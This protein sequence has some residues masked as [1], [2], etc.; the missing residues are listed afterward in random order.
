MTDVIGKGVI[1]VSADATKM[2]A[3]IGEAKRSIK[4]LGEAT[5]SVSKK[6]SDSIDRYVKRLEVQAATVGKS[7]RETKLYE[8]ALRGASKAQ[9]DA[10][11][12]ALRQAEGYERGLRIGKSLGPSLLTIGKAAV[13]AGTGLIAVAAGF[14][15]FIKKAGSFQDLAEKTGDTAQN[16]ASLAVAAAVGGVEMNTVAAASVKLT[17]GLT[18]VDDETKGA[19]AAI[20]ALG[21]DLQAFKQLAPADQFETVAKA[22]AGF[23]NGAQQ[24]AVAV[25]LFGKSGADILPFLKELSQE[26]SRQVILTTEQIKLAD[27]YADKQAKSRAQ[28]S[29]LASSIATQAIPAYTALQDALSDTIKAL[30]GVGSASG[31]LAKRNDVKDFAETGALALAVLADGAYFIAQ[32]FRLVGDNIGSTAAQAAALARLDFAGAAAIGRASN[33]FNENLKLSLG[34]AD[35]LQAKFAAINGASGFKLPTRPGQGEKDKPTLNFNGAAKSGGKDTA[36]QE[37]ASQLAFDLDQIKKASAATLNSFS[38]AERIL[39]AKRSA[40]LVQEGEYYEAKLR[41]LNVNRAEQ[42]RALNA[43]IARLQAEKLVGKDKIDND[44]KIMDAQARLAKVREDAATSIEVQGIQQ[45]AALK[46]I[47]Q[48]YR[49]AEDAANEFLNTLRKGN[50][51]ELAGIGAGSQERDRT[52]G[53]AQ[54]EDRFNSQRQDLEKSRRDAQ[55]NGTFGPDAQKKYDDELDRIRRFQGAALSEYDTFFVA[56]LAKEHDFTNGATEALANYFTASQNI[57]EQIDGLFT[58]AFQGMEDA[59]VNFVTTGKLDFKSLANSIIADISRIII[60]Q[61]ILGPLASTLSGGVSS[62]T[63][64]GGFISSLLGNIFGGARALGG[65]VSAGKLYEVNEKGPELLTA[66]NKQFLM[67]GAQSGNVSPNASA[68]GSAQ[69]RTTSMQITIN[70]PSGMTRQA[71]SQFAADVARQLRLADARN[72]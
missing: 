7:T 51:R 20:T 3:G 59:L 52:S 4:E 30:F 47:E 43:E 19:G 12:A 18:G 28:L 1:E 57:A 32:L 34:L 2:K 29:L 38:N 10:A 49:D 39:E 26:G 16:F 50:A 71:S 9:L 66:G 72:A 37:A 54:I 65:P 15:A 61:Q 17:K 58:N 22:L 31:D 25:A 44:R 42:E 45:T 56:R 41:F 33:D 46:A 23:K 48:G 55:L 69:A 67:M 6:A 53:R 64:G 68:S 70:P 8:L 24:T 14:D 36:K 21:L 11:N 60:K 13:L 62:G 35:R 27:D 40:A 5:G 63:G